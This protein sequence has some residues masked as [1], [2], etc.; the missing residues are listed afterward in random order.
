LTLFVP[1][2]AGG[3]DVEMPKKFPPEFRRDV[4]EVRVGVI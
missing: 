1:G 4:A 3:K 2:V